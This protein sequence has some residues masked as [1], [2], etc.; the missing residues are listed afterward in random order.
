MKK[1]LGAVLIA[2]AMTVFAGLLVNQEIQA[3]TAEDATGAAL[4]GAAA[5]ISPLIAGIIA[6]G[7]V[8][9]LIVSV[10]LFA[11]LIFLII[12]AIVAIGGS[13]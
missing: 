3:P 5:V 11:G 6:A 1:F 4:S 2:M 13:S 7:G 8:T 12:K 10:I 9:G